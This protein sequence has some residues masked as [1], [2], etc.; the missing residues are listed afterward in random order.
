M[1]EFP[2][3][4]LNAC[5][6]AMGELR[7]G[8]AGATHKYLASAKTLDPKCMLI[9]Q[10]E[11]EMAQSTA[12]KDPLLGGNSVFKTLLSEKT[13]LTEKTVDSSP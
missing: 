10:A 13:L 4:A 12:K 8:D 2:C 1:P 3:K 6:L 7:R 9:P 5:H 11:A